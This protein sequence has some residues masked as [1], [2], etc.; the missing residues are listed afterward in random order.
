MRMLGFDL[1]LA[2]CL[3]SWACR[4]LFGGVRAQEAQYVPGPLLQD[5]ENEVI[6]LE[7]ELLPSNPSGVRAHAF[8]EASLLL[9]PGAMQ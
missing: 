1:C 9:L 4:V 5:G 3:L 8:S 6:M 2:S 7:T